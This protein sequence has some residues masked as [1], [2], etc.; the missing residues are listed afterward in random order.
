MSNLTQLRLAARE[1]FDETLRTVDPEEAVRGTV[2]FEGRQLRVCDTVLNLSQTQSVYSIA[3]GKAAFGMAR[4]L[5]EKIGASLAA[6][7]LAS[8]VTSPAHPN[9]LSA[10]ALTRWQIFHG[11]HPEPNEQS[12]AAAR[13]CFELLKRAEAEQ[14]LLIFLISGGGSAMLEWPIDES[15]T[16]ADLRTANRALVGSGASIAEINAIRRS[17]SA[18]KGGRLAG[19][20]QSCAQLTLIVSDVAAGE[21]RNVASGPT[22]APPRNAPDPHE[23]IERYDL[24]SQLPEAIL[25]AIEADSLPFEDVG[26]SL[27]RHFVLLDNHSALE[28]V[29]EAARRRGFVTETAADVA[30]Q[31]IQEGCA[32][33]LNRLEALQAKVSKG[34]TVCL[35]SGG[36]FACP[37]RGDGLGGRNLETA[38]RLAGARGSSS[39]EQFVALC[40]GTDGIDGNSPAAGAIVDSTTIDRAGAIG[41]EPAEFIERSDVYS[42]FVALGD[43]VATGAT[44]TNVRDVRIL[45]GSN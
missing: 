21:E 14:A 3:I 40:A 32:Q 19:R 25:H 37:V 33:L 5:D 15:I 7:V 27:R 43:V 34:E 28:A 44:G 6:G 8:T 39:S 29:T 1:I 16:L 11:G 42:F 20:A 24:R 2:H 12:L 38:L 22:L 30:D 18:V 35:I 36:E 41:L 23:V 10:P 13:A 45:L 17:F 9:A 31:P 26:T 4:A